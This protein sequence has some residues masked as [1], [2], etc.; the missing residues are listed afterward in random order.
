MM[1]LDAVWRIP[2]LSPE[3]N[4]A[5]TQTAYETIKE[6]VR[7]AEEYKVFKNGS[8]K[9]F[10]SDISIYTDADISSIKKLLTYRYSDLCLSDN[11]KKFSKLNNILR[12][13]EDEGKKLGVPISVLLGGKVK[14]KVHV[15]ATG[16][17]Y[18]R[19]DFDEEVSERI[20]EANLY[21]EKG[22]N[23][24]KIKIGALKTSWHF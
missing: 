15:Y 4:S 3:V 2:F 23:A 19:K 24:M 20:K 6:V 18:T 12:L 11:F 17:Y 22:F 21:Q 8:F 14:D 5:I 16:L 10:I 13:C 7:I 9:I 1:S